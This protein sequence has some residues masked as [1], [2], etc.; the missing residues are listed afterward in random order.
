M[1]DLASIH[2][3]LKAHKL[4]DTTHFEQMN[5]RFDEVGAKL[6]EHMASSEKFREDITPYLQ[7]VAG[8]KILYKI[9]LAAG[10]VAVAW[11]ALRNAFP[12][13]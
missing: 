11:I 3:E 7:A 10:S 9:F 6:D 1:T 13:L 12:R 5:R 4:E 2:E 8:T